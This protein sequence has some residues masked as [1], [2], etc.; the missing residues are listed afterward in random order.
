[1]VQ[2]RM[3]KTEAGICRDGSG[4]NASARPVIDDNPPGT[5]SFRAEDEG[6]WPWCKDLLFKGS[7]SISPAHDLVVERMHDQLS[8]RLSGILRLIS[9]HEKGVVAYGELERPL[10]LL[11]KCPSDLIGREMTRE[12]LGLQAE[13]RAQRFLLE[14]RLNPLREEQALFDNALEGLGRPRF[15]RAVL[16]ALAK[17]N[18]EDDSREY[19]ELG[20][21]PAPLIALPG[22]HARFHRLLRQFVQVTA[23]GCSADIS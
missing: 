6:L 17:V 23:E 10:R 20:W 12:V 14:D 18:S 5:N 11:L 1:M 13:C 19:I 22:L 3:G 2:V 9:L 15:S 4:L 8:E 21:R 16:E 7:L